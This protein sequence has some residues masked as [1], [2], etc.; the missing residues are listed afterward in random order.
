MAIPRTSIT[1]ALTDELLDAMILIDESRTGLVERVMRERLG[2][3]TIKSVQAKVPEIRGGARVG[4]GRPSRELKFRH[5]RATRRDIGAMMVFQSHYR[6]EHQL[7]KGKSGAWEKIRV[8]LGTYGEYLKVATI[9]HQIVGT[10][11]VYPVNH[12]TIASVLC[13]D[14]DDS[15]LIPTPG[16]EACY[17]SGINILPSHRKSRRVIHGLMAEIATT[18]AELTP[19]MVYAQPATPEGKRL[20]L[21]LGFRECSGQKDAA[22]PLYECFA[23][24]AAAVWQR[25]ALRG[26][27]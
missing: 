26:Q 15:S 12:A 21:R 23:E 24:D 5:P 11:G 9:G 1:M 6:P 19:S 25:L 17:I 7:S 13:G 14:L 8:S 16:G 20:A 22:D 10:V 3:E 4:A 2:L 18:I 27:D